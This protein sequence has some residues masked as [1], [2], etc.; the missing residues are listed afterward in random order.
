MQYSQQQSSNFGFLFHPSG[1]RTIGYK[2]LF[3]IP[4]IGLTANYRHENFEFGAELKYSGWVL[5]PLGCAP[6]LFL[7][8]P[9]SL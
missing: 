6:F 5:S 4:Y 1:E 2:Q 3:K 9:F 7:L 8:P